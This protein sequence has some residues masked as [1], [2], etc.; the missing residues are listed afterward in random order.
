[1]TN[2]IA[3]LLLFALAALFVADHFWL[4]LDLPRFLGRKLLD[5]IEYIAFWR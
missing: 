3:L 5:L 4:G 2:R 1:M